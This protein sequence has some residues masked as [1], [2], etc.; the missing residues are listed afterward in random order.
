M[1][2]GDVGQM[3]DGY[4]VQVGVGS[5]SHAG[6]LV[7]VVHDYDHWG[8]GRVVE[9]DYSRARDLARALLIAADRVGPIEE[10]PAVTTCK[11]CGHFQIDG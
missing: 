3:I 11:H 9:V 1:I 8:H 7:V 10:P 2:P 4:Q 5:G 6:D